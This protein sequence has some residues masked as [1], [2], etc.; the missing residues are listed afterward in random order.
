MKCCAVAL[1]ALLMLSHGSQVLAN[2]LA[3]RIAEDARQFSEEHGQKLIWQGIVQG[4]AVVAEIWQSSEGLWMLSLL[5]P[6]RVSC[7]QLYGEGGQLMQPDRQAYE[8]PEVQT[9]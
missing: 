7:L 3:C 2:P 8:R 1:I 4:G 6:M 9:P 5:T